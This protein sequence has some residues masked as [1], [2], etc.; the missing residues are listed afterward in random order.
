MNSDLED[1]FREKSVFVQEN[2]VAA[3]CVLL[4]FFPVQFSFALKWL[5]SILGFQLQ[6]SECNANVVGI[7]PVWFLLL[8]LV[9][10]SFRLSPPKLRL[11]LIFRSG[12]H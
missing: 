3:F 4:L 1:H 5:T 2:R 10:L 8:R 7:L 12:I 6:P 11:D 9:S